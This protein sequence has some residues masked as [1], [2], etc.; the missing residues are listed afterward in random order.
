MKDSAIKKAYKRD[1]LEVICSS[2]RRI[3][4]VI[5]ILFL[6]FVYAFICMAAL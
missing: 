6:P 2:K 3:F 4:K 1:F 5:A